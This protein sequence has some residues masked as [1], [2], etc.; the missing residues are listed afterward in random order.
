MHFPILPSSAKASVM[1]VC[2]LPARKMLKALWREA[3][4]RKD[5]LVFMDFV[6]DETENVFSD[7][8]GRQRIVGD[9]AGGRIINASRLVHIDGKR[10]GGRYRAFPTCFRL[11]PITLNHSMWRQPKNPLYRA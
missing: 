8:G 5:D 6:T 7:G 10:A 2:T 1:S 9:G 4:A 11:A 3:F